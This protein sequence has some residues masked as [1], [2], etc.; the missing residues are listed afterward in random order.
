VVE[1]LA[2]DTGPI[3][4]YPISDIQHLSLRLLPKSRERLSKT[5]AV[6][7]SMWK[8]VDDGVIR[9]RID[10]W[11]SFCSSPPQA[12]NMLMAAQAFVLDTLEIF[13]LSLFCVHLPHILSL[14]FRQP[15]LAPSGSNHV[16]HPFG[17]GTFCQRF[18]S[19]LAL[20]LAPP[21]FADI[22]DVNPAHWCMIL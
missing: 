19:S 4:L 21:L 22:S 15:T 10:T 13:E 14:V 7:G 11:L 16:V 1:S 20:H 3:S 2:S 5:H 9:G 17:P 18:I 6:A 12:L 8:D